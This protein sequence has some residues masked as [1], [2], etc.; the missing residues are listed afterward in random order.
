MCK[1]EE[2]RKQVLRLFGTDDDIY[3]Y[4]NIVHNHSWR[5]ALLITINIMRM[6]HKRQGQNVWDKRRDQAIDAKELTK[7]PN[8]T[9]RKDKT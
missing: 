5:K 2:K 4:E 8:Y 3:T 1:N 6:L 9:E 7:F